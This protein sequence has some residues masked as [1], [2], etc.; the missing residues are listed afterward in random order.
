M[1][2]VIEIVHTSENTSERT[3]KSLGGAVPKSSTYPQ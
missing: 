1:E 3:Q 2:K